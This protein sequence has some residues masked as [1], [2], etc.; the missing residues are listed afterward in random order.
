[1]SVGLGF[2]P[3][4]HGAR[5]RQIDLQRNPYLFTQLLILAPYLFLF[6]VG[7]AGDPVWGRVTEVMA[8]PEG[9]R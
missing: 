6:L 7:F 4:G 9:T 1:M 2:G 5:A 8:R 3:T